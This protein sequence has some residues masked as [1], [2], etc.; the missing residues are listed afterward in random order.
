MATAAADP[1]T[2][3][4]VPPPGPYLA[5]WWLPGGHLQTLWAYLRPAPQLPLRWE[6]WERADGDFN[7]LAWLDGPR[8]APLVVLFHGL[9]GSA[10][11]HYARHLLW[12]LKARG[13]RGVVAHFRGCSGAPN[14]LPRAYHAGDSV[15]IAAFLAHL[16]PQ[17]H[18]AP[19]YAV[20]V[21]L[22]GNALLKWLGEMGLKAAAWVER[23]AAVSTPM[24][25][26]A[27]ARAL[28]R[29]LNRLYTWH[30][31]SSLKAKMRTKHAG[32]LDLK[33]LWSMRAFDQRVTAP[34]HGFASAE[35]YW[36]LSAARPWLRHIAV[37]TL[38]LNARND[39]MVPAASLPGPEEVSPQVTLEYP[40][41]GGHAGFVSGP[42]PG[43]M[44][45]LPR[46][47][48]AFFGDGGWGMSDEG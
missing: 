18:P 36:R 5:P 2:E 41:A 45:W 48:L 24:D 7:D 16:K 22:G 29:G 4:L 31:L 19:L 38:I 39:P 21:S 17:A 30:F 11:S 15:E 32:Q 9:E 46:R 3:A 12:A 44:D 28:D 25:M 27:A 14:R 34:L 6:R 42:F 1:G 37:P 40:E 33:G 10:H 23:A 47:L 13:W 35:D 26:P 8:H 43:R 20:G